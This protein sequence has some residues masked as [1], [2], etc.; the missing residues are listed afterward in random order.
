VSQTTQGVSN[1]TAEVQSVAGFASSDL[2]S[3]NGKTLF[4]HDGT[5]SLSVDFS[6]T[7][8][9][10]AAVVS[11]ITSA[12]GYSDLDFGV[13]AGSDAL[14]LTY[15][16]S[17]GNVELAQVS[18]LPPSSLAVTQ[19]T[20]GVASSTA[21]VQ[22]VAGFASSDLSSL[23][24]KTLFLHDGT[25]S[26]SVDFSSTPSNLAAVVTA[27]T[28]ATGYSDLDFTV[29]AGTNALTLTY[30][31]SDGDV[32]LADVGY[33]SA[34]ETVT[35]VDANL[36]IDGVPITRKSNTISDLIDGMTLTLNSTT[37]SAETV[38]GSFDSDSAYLAFSLFID[39]INTI[40]TS[41]D[42]LTDRGGL[43]TDAGPLAGDP[44]ASSLKNQLSSILNASIPGFDEEEI[45]LAYFGFETQQDGSFV[46]N[47]DTFADYFEANPAHFSAFF[48]SRVST[49]SALIS[50]SMIGDN[51]TA[52][53]YSFV[54]DDN[55]NGSVGDTNLTNTGNI[56]SS[57]SGDVSGLFIE[58]QTGAD[59]TTLY[60]GRSLLDTLASF[61][62]QIL[63]TSGDISDKVSDLNTSLLDYQDDVDALD[64]RMAS[65]KE[66][67]NEQFGAMEAAIANMKSTETTIT[68]MMEAWKGSMKN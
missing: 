12:T 48:N 17:D 28:S 41:L 52:G 67:Y 4:L 20:K 22:S 56:Y 68:N 65:L 1:T 63:S 21:E 61:T 39:E 14:T 3:L 15:N 66:R 31:S 54:I 60:V 50:A 55:G 26:L 7:P 33:L 30:N 37:S 16:S 23:N 51:Y 27:I 35:A 40:K 38:S 19:T 42:K 13:G 46:V 10:L 2:S 9:D 58:T 5:N 32:E 43:T 6:S 57:L 45:Y 59:D 62:S 44:V 53:V 34:T 29:S 25:N 11:A 64:E 8:S 47:Q 49:N 24:G 36:T 18:I